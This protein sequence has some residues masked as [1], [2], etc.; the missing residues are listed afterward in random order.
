MNQLAAVAL[1]VMR[2]KF[3]PGRGCEILN[4][5]AEAMD[6]LAV[7]MGGTDERNE[8]ALTLR[9]AERWEKITD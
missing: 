3:P 5:A 8:D 7:E 4:P 1:A 6:A 9:P 2:G